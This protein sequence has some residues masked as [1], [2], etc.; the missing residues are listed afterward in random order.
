M[1]QGE[2]YRNVSD[3]LNSLSF[4][5]HVRF[6][7]Q[8]RNEEVMLLLRQ[9]PITQVPWVLNAFGLALIVILLNVILPR[10][11]DPVDILFINI[12]GFV[13]VGAYAWLNFLSWFFNVGIVT[14][15]RILDV[16]FR[17]VLYKE[18]NIAQLGNV[19]E[20]TS[21][22]AGYI[23]SLFNYGHVEVSTAGADVNIEFPNVPNP[24]IVIKFINQLAEAQNGNNN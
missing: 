18:V 17:N 23:G 10:F 24:S 12:F 5:P 6:D 21:K 13:L 16:D 1:D 11:F 14:N 19:E 9:H 2:E 20:M 4:Y 22:T 15:E 3:Y 7:L 8:H